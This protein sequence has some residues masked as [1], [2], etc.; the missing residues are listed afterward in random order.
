MSNDITVTVRG[1]SGTSA[2]LNENPGRTPWSQIRLASTPS[3]RTPEGGW[4]DGETTWFTVKTFG[5]QARNV[6]AS[7]RK[8]DALVVVGRL[9]TERWTTDAGEPRE[10]M[11]IMAESVA[12]DLALGQARFTRV[13]HGRLPVGEASEPGTGTQAPADDAAPGSPDLDPYTAGPA[14]GEDDEI[15][16]I[17]ARYARERELAPAF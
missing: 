6:A 5:D 3:L 15:D 16:E 10:S 1:F 7:V 12:L 9:R 17:E 8:G 13:V 2:K 4:R 14:A 11:V